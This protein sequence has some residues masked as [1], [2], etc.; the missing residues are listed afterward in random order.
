MLGIRTGRRTD[1]CCR[2]DEAAVHPD[3]GGRPVDAVQPHRRRR[4]DASPSVSTSWSSDTG[5]D[6]LMVSTM[7][8]GLAE[9]I[10]TLEL[11]ADHADRPA[12]DPA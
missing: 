12:G 11:V 5:A 4:R 2:P 6:E 3:I 8:Y 1:R 7:T 10:R 9:R